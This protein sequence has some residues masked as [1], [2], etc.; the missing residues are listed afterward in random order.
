MAPGAE[1]DQVFFGIQA[2][3]TPKQFVVDFQVRGRA[4][5][6]TPPPVATQ[7]LLPEALVGRGIESQACESWPIELMMPFRSN[8]QEMPVADP[9]AGI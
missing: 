5:R 3:V 7:D 6:L 2:G 8:L 9:R 4:A 1:C